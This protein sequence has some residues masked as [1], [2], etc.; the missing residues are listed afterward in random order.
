M[1]GLSSSVGSKYRPAN[2]S[3]V[4]RYAICPHWHKLRG[5]FLTGT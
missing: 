4:S 3:D 2:I 1:S 5:R